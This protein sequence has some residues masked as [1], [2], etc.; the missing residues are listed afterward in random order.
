MLRGIMASIRITPEQKDYLR[1]MYLKFGNEP[2]QWQEAKEI[3]SQG[4]FKKFCDSRFI[5]KIGLVSRLT[6]PNKNGRKQ[7]T[8]I[9]EW[10]MDPDYVRRFI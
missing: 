1:S 9:N 7:L 8:K 3:I 2:F 10:K 4:L 6:T 5:T